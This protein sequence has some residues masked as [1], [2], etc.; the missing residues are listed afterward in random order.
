MERVPFAGLAPDN[1]PSRSGGDLVAFNLLTALTIGRELRRSC[2]DAGS[3]DAFAGA[4]V[5]AVNSF[6]HGGRPASVLVRAFVTIP[7]KELPSSLE[8][9]VRAAAPE[10]AP[11][12]N[13]VC[14]RLLATRGLEPGWGSVEASVAHRAVLLEGTAAPMI[15]ELARQ[16]RLGAKTAAP[17]ASFYVGDPSVSPA[18]PA[19][20]FLTA[21]DVCS[22]F[23]FGMALAPMTSIVV[24]A[25]SRAP[26]ERTTARLFET[27]GLYAKIAWLSS[28][29]AR[30]LLAEDWREALILGSDQL[31]TLLESHIHEAMYDYRRR[32]DDAATAARRAADQA[33]EMAEAHARDVRQRQRAMLNVIEDLREARNTLSTTVEQ[34]TRELAAANRQLESRNRELEEFVYIAS[35]DLQE[36][37]R[38]VAG[39]L[40][41]IQRRYGNKLGVEADEF[42]RFATEGA[43][44]MQALIESLL[45]YSR[46]STAEKPPELVQLDDAVDIA[47]QNLAR[48]IEETN[49]TIERTRPLPTV[50]GDRIQMVQLF[51]NLLSNALKFAGDKPPRIQLTSATTDSSCT[52][53]VRDEGIGFNPKFSDRIFKVFR[54]LRRDT[55]GTGIGLA[56]CKKIVER[57]GGHIEA[58]AAPGAGATFTIHLPIPS[59]ETPA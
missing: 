25:F 53:A 16:L 35:H 14:L 52:V 4:L 3:M 9:A 54:R 8:S 49:A 20:A 44:R 10:L 5:D 27:V 2:A 38:T 56:V 23:G 6:D 59:H 22:V 32:L 39:Y 33:A 18:V 36:P 34:R 37:L 26:I 29:H 40:Q 43:Q 24:V 1:R 50:R 51:Q 55:P 15:S 41:M 11:D 57:H 31:V 21:Y 45:V 28:P 47:L 42:I 13:P 30:E 12:A 19:K 48:R 7:L 46:V 17:I 58:T